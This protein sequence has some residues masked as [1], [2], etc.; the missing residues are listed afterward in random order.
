MAN[1][2]DLLEYKRYNPPSQ[3]PSFV[4]IGSVVPA[5]ATS[6]VQLRIR[7]IIKIK[8]GV[9]IR[10]SKRVRLRKRIRI[11][12]RIKIRIRKRRT[13]FQKLLIFENVFL[14]FSAIQSNFVKLKF[15]RNLRP[16][17]RAKIS[18]IY[19]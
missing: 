5:V 16:I 3:R 18:S 12:L 2:Y 13:N 6:T 7:I 17:L 11:R 14:Y 10:I 19:I 1:K 8:I 15:C 4:E 9:R